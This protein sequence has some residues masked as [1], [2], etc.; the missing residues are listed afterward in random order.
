MFGGI[1]LFIYGG[2]EMADTSYKKRKLVIVSKTR[3]CIFLII[4]F[5]IFLSII[6]STF[7]NTNAKEKLGQSSLKIVSVQKGDTLWDISNK[8]APRNMDKRKYIYEVRK[9]N[10]MKS[11]YLLEGQKIKLPD[12]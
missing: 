4:V 10:N 5:V 6:A 12:F 11:A 9:I 7:N 2:I 1:V 3:F 8:Y